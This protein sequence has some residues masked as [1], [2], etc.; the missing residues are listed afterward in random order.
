MNNKRNSVFPSLKGCKV[1]NA[2]LIAKELDKN[3]NFK[4][5]AF[6]S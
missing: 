4:C 2:L 1:M 6:R 5:I 3:L